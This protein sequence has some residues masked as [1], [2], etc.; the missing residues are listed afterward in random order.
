MTF[1]GGV[2]QPTIPGGS[3]QGVAYIEGVVT[4]IDVENN[5]VVLTDQLLQT[6]ELP[7]SGYRPKGVAPKVGERWILHKQFGRWFW[8]GIINGSPQGEL[9]DRTVALTTQIANDEKDR[10]SFRDYNTH[11]GDLYSTC[12]RREMTAAHA[13]LNQR[14]Y[15]FRTFARYTDT[16]R[17]LKV[18]FGTARV[19]GDCTVGFYMGSDAN[20]LPAM[21]WVNGFSGTAVQVWSF[22]GDFV[23][24]GG[25]HLVFFVVVTGAPSTMPTL[26][27]PPAVPFASIIN[28]G[29]SRNTSFYKDGISSVPLTLNMNDGSWT[30]AANTVWFTLATG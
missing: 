10:S 9:D 1:P 11:G 13:T 20:A 26:L 8:A 7:L 21:G 12:A 18:A 24:Y 28:R 2:S 6:R 14:M 15:C 4:A 23:V 17:A 22:G 30:T 5:K 16:V 3:G 27:G 29:V 19:G 25:M